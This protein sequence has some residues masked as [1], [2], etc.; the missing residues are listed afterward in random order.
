MQRATGSLPGQ[1]TRSHLL[2]LRPS[3]TKKKKK[4]LL[5][6]CLAWFRDSHLAHLFLG[7]WGPIPCPSVM[8]CGGGWEFPG[9][10]LYPPPRQLAGATPGRQMPE[11][12]V[13]A[14]PK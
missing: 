9:L 1:G 10:F 14:V 8:G 5:C 3:A 12:M 6:R 4:D 7:P 11:Q 2:L 13:L